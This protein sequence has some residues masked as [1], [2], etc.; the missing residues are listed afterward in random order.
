MDID[1]TVTGFNDIY[2]DST[3]ERN[4]G[5]EMLCLCQ[6][7]NKVFINLENRIGK[8]VLVNIYMLINMALKI[9]N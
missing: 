5:T 4:D 3:N 9:N 7:K 2:N 6:K 8:H 1:Q